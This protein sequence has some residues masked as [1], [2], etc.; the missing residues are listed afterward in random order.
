VEA[1]G[2]FVDSVDDGHQTSAVSKGL[3]ASREQTHQ[4][5]PATPDANTRA[6][7]IENSV[8]LTLRAPLFRVEPGQLV[9]ICG[10]V[11]SG[12]SSLL[13]ALLGELQ[14]VPPPD[15]NVGDPISGAPVVSG[16]VAYCQQIPWIEAGTVKDNILFGKPM[17]ESWYA[18]TLP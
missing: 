15:Y 6:E 9:G 18:P 5:I 8:S 16:S 10:E 3:D 12:K 14:P 7:A 2:H 17:E 13:S 1:N 11:G 4:S